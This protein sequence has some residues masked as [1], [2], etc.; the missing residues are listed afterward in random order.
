MPQV[1]LVEQVVDRERRRQQAELVDPRAGELDLRG[2]RV[3]VPELGLEVAA[4]VV[5][6]HEARV[7]SGSSRSSTA[8]A[9]DVPLARY[10]PRSIVVNH[11][12]SPVCASTM[13][14][15]DRTSSG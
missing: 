11:T 2:V 13:F 15:S 1:A 5:L 4:E 3:A 8:V 12:A 9:S 6:D 10:V 14:A 7:A